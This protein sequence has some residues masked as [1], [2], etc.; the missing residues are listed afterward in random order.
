MKDLP[1]TLLC[2]PF[3]TAVQISEEG[4]AL[5]SLPFSKL[6]F[7]IS[8]SFFFQRDVTHLHFPALPD[9]NL[10]IESKRNQVIV[11]TLSSPSPLFEYSAYS[12]PIDYM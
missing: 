3:S 6:H 7:H 9:Q 4:S 12:G 10:L 8:F 11:V 2:H 5:S 1:P